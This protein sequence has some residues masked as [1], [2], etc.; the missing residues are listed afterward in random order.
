MTPEHSKGFEISIEPMGRILWVRAWGFWDA[1]FGKK[2]IS[3]F[4]EKVAELGANGKEWYALMDLT[5]F[6]PGAPD[7]QNML[8]QQIMQ[9]TKQGIRKAAYPGKISAAQVYRHV[10]LLTSN[11][12]QDAFV[13][14]EEEALQWLLN[15]DGE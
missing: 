11:L 15:R 4:T 12:P 3:A 7:V 14:S 5:E 8:R 6:H 2:Y 10:L 13:E 1:D 9:A